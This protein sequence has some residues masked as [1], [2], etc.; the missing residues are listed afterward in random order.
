MFN[1]RITNCVNKNGDLVDTG[2]DSNMFFYKL[3][4][5]DTEGYGSFHVAFL[6][7]KYRRDMKLLFDFSELIRRDGNIERGNYEKDLIIDSD[8]SEMFFKKDLLMQHK[9]ELIVF[10]YFG[11]FVY[12]EPTYIYKPAIRL[13]CGKRI[14]VRYLSRVQR[15]RILKNKLGILGKR[16]KGRC[17]FLD[18]GLK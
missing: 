18:M 7:K 15:A 14:S 4:F 5:T 6:V 16:N 11:A 2:F 9:G 17:L 1:L 3:E 10:R 13:Q 12:I 8:G